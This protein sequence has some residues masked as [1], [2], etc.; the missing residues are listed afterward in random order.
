VLN[1]ASDRDKHW[2]I[3]SVKRHHKDKKRVKEVI[4]YV[5]DNGGLEYAIRQMN[6]YRDAALGLLVNYPE[7]TFKT[8]LVDL[9]NYVVDRKK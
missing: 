4:T 7:S 5:K 2:I 8:A 6:R 3:D 1:Q 9:V